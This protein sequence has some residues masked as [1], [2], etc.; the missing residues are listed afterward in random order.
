M[1]IEGYASASEV[2]RN[3]AQVTGKYAQV[4][5]DRRF[6]VVQFEPPY[7]GGS[8]F[9]VVN[10]KGFLWEPVDTLKDALTYLQSAEALEYQASTEQA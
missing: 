4:H 10:E 2:I 5:A 9:W 3:L 7:L 6:A 8:E 1:K